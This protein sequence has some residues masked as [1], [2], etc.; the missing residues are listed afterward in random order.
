M[1]KHATITRT[2]RVQQELQRH[3]NQQVL[4]QQGDQFGRDDEPIDSSLPLANIDNPNS[5]DISANG[6]SSSPSWLS[7]DATNTTGGGLQFTSSCNPSPSPKSTPTS[8]FCIS[9]APSSVFSSPS[10]TNPNGT[11]SDNTLSGSSTTIDTSKTP[12]SST[13]T[14]TTTTTRTLSSASKCGSESMIKV[15]AQTLSQEVEYVTLHVNA[16]TKS[17]QIIRSLLR[18]FRLKH[19]DPN[20]FYLTLERWIRKDGLKQKSVMLLSDQACPLQLQQC[21]SNPPHND[22][23]FTLQMRAGALIKIHCSD[24]CPNTRYKCLSL[25]TQT[26]VDE[27][28]ELMLH[29]LNLVANGTG[30]GTGTTPK[31]GNTSVSSQF[32]GTSSRLTAGSPIL[33]DS[34]STT[35]S[36]SSS[37]TTSSSSGIDSDPMQANQ[38]TSHHSSNT[39]FTSRLLDSSSRTNSVTSISSSSNVSN[40]SSSHLGEQFC[41]IIECRDTNYRRILESD[42]YLVDVYQNLLDEARERDHLSNLSASPIGGHDGVKSPLQSDLN[43]SPTKQQPDQ[44]FLIKLKRREDLAH[45][46]IQST[47]PRQ[48]MP[49]PPIPLSL[50]QLNNKDH[51]QNIVSTTQIEVNHQHRSRPLPQ[52][53]QHHRQTS[54]LATSTSNTSQLQSTSNNRAA[55]SVDGYFPPAAVPRNNNLIHHRQMSAIVASNHNVLTTNHHNNA[56]MPPPPASL[57]WLPPIR[58][59]RR[60]LSNASTSTFGRPHSGATANGNSTNRRRY[61]PAQLAEDLDKLEMSDSILVDLAPTTT[62]CADNLSP[63]VGPVVENAIVSTINSDGN[64]NHVIIDETD[65]VEPLAEVRE[66]L[67]AHMA[68]QMEP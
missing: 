62:K 15:F 48:N 39:I 37:S 42:E 14:T 1:L 23:K 56:P 43:K 44:W 21:C 4:L 10:K 11:I 40:T 27:T 28:I 8:K 51:L 67:N 61:D 66:E 2:S 16:Q 38:A 9:S 55:D 19:R 50:S 26:S 41:L 58:P 60:N 53:L 33:T 30:T 24:V 46:S 20:L 57:I 13:T 12:I 7:N 59:R 5:S 25:S 6:M 31:N 35:S 47:N 17:S 45:Q 29:C 54:S 49:L 52:P 36:S 32:N 64:V 68:D 34:S 22:I 18:K 65:L 3:W 63:N